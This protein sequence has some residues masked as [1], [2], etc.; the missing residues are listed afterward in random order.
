MELTTPLT[1]GFHVVTV[2]GATALKLKML[3]RANVVPFCSID[4][5]LPTAYMTWPHWTSLR[6]CSGI[7]VVASC[8]VPLAGVA[9]TVASAG[10]DAEKRSSAAPADT[11]VA[12]RVMS[13]RRRKDGRR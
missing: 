4:V 1:F 13:G 3:L 11:V 9:F 7:P 8:G 10:C 2:Y 6:I 5:K 12:T